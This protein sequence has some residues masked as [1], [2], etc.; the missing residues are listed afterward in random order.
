MRMNS[1]EQQKAIYA[2]FWNKYYREETNHL[3]DE[4][5]RLKGLNN[6]LEAELREAKSKIK[7]LKALV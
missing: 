4:V 5:L 1:H 7:M 3:R 2:D 6:K